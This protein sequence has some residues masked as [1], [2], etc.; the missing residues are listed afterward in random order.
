[1]L[2]LRLS[3]IALA[4][5]LITVL[6]GNLIG[7][8]EQSRGVLRH[9][10]T[11]D[12]LTSTPGT[13]AEEQSR[14][15]L[16]FLNLRFGMFIHFNMSTFHSE[17]WANPFHDP[18]SF[19]P[20]S[21]DCAQWARAAKSAGMNYAVFTA[22]HHDGF[23]LWDTRVTEYD[24]ARSPCKRDLVREYVDAFRRENIKVGLYFSV[25]DRHHKVEPGNITPA[26][27][28]FTKDELTELLSNYGKIE[29][30]VIDGWGS[31]WGGPSF[32]ELPFSVLADHIHSL[33]PDCLVINHSCKT[34][35]GLTQIVHYEATH[36]QHCPYDNTI[37]SEQGPT[38]QPAWFWEPGFESGPLKSV[39]AVVNELRFAN[40][41]YCNYLLNA[42]PNNRGLMDDNVVA[43]LAEIG[44]AVQF[45]PPLTALPKMEKPHKNVTVTASSFS[46]N[47]D[48]CHVVDCDLFTRWQPKGD[49]P[50]PW[51]ELDF[52][53][54]ETFNAVVCG[55]FDQFV[56]AF[57]IEANV[58]GQW[59]ELA[60]GDKMTFNYQ[61]SFP[62]VTAQK[63]RLVLLKYRPSPLV[64]EVTFIKY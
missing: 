62:D 12:S 7:A 38:L 59:I 32:D 61:A 20:M 31:K 2:K 53:K 35:L 41:H 24:I 54:P 52:G 34:D 17:Q 11:K 37:P 1:M 21:L 60:R 6:A 50:E 56:D 13:P 4:I 47:N 49:D 18:K 39:D 9:P 28:Q 16:N 29:C 51:V 40:R 33:Q 58:G 42:A 30:I 14:N 43:R 55:E 27:N 45:P 19:N 10:I 36:G 3:D 57:K 48:P 25:W 8:E 5:S 64:A 44:K 46:P 26:T 23:C 63:Y 22:K 15:I